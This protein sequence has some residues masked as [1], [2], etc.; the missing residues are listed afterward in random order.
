VLAHDDLVFPPSVSARDHPARCLAY[1]RFTL[2]Y[3]DVEDLLA[4]RGLDVSY[5]TG[6]R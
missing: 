2:T 1:V 6:R 3:R 5:E 4:E